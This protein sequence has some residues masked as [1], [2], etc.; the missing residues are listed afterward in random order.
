M[1]KIFSTVA[2]AAALFAGYSAYNEQNSN[3]LS[4]VALAN[5]EAL[6]GSNEGLDCS[7]TREEG[8]CTINVGAKGEIKLLNGSIIKAGTSGEISF[9]GKVVC[10]AG[11]NLT[12]T[13]VECITL[14]TIIIDNSN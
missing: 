3:E 13:P 1:K 4:D 6:A 2:I 11:G 9:D 8:K 5:V 14:Y 10:G 12:C 7:Y